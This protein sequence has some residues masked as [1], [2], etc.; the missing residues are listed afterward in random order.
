MHR[1]M[2]LNRVLEE[3][4]IKMS[5][6]GDGFFWIGGPGEEGFGVPLGLQVRKGQGNDFDYL[7]LHYRSS[8]IALAMGA[9]PIDTIRQMRTAVTDPYS[10][11]RNFVNHYCIPKWN[12]MP[13]SP[14]IETQYSTVIG[15]AIAQKRHGGDGLSIVTGGDAGTA[16]GDFHS[17]LVWATR[18]ANPLPILIVV[19]NN[20]YGISTPWKDQHGEGSISN[21]AKAFEGMPG[22]TIN[23][24]DPVES[25]RAIQEAIE[26]I[27][28]TRGPYLLEAK[29]S[30]LHGHSSSSGANRVDEVDCIEVFEAEL[31][32]RG[33]MKTED[34][35]KVWSDCQKECD[36]A[37]NQVKKEPYPEPED[38]WNG[39]F[40]EG[41]DKSYPKKGGS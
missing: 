10:R 26:H 13:V 19:V 31:K 1:L 16:E 2:V 25:Y 20:A 7:H 39:V 6:G 41:V 17:C 21:W 30:R 32:K 8:G 12:I 38:I 36:E 11:G 4:L 35:K 29:T 9:K 40:V 37:Y 22:K 33:L 28:K 18:P 27:R 5:K 14:T 24:N 34:L 15:T 3:R 23:G